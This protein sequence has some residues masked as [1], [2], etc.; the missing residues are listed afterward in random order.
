M[1]IFYNTVQ[2]LILLLGLPLWLAAMIRPKRRATFLYRLGVKG[3]YQAQPSRPGSF[4]RPIWIHALSVGEV[5][6][7]Q[8]LVEALDR[9]L[10]GI[11]LVFSAS[12]RT[13]MQTAHRLFGG[14][15][16]SLFYFPYD[17]FLSVR[18]VAGVINPC[19]VVIVETDIWPNFLDHLKQRRVPVVWVN[20]RLSAGTFRGFRMMGKFSRRLLNDFNGIGAQSPW[21]ADRLRDLGI[22]PEKIHITGNVKFDQPE[23]KSDRYEGDAMKKAL[24]IPTGRRILIMGSTH[25]GEE[26]IGLAV[27]N[28]LRRAFDDL[29]IIVAP[30]DPDRAGAVLAR[31]QAMG[32][33]GGFLSS[34]TTA[35]KGDPCE[36]LVVNTMGLLR[37]LYGLADIAFVGGSLVAQGGHNPLEPAAW[38]KP[39]L[40]GPDMSDFNAV[41]HM[42]EQGGGAVRVAGLPQ[43]RREMEKM[44]ADAPLRVRRGQLALKV[45]QS[46]KGAVDKTLLLV[47]QA[48]GR[49]GGTARRNP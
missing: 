49:N 34:L 15:V 45:F 3:P 31:A 48:L 41:A 22:P 4:Q 13:G 39:I 32:M 10:P 35:A 37:P 42:L 27:Y 14:K 24:G 21:D 9:R 6:S 5:M 44:L 28:D 36:V 2:I 23:D 18:R 29:M 7:A 25:P 20:A 46:N 1:V 38:A 30:R 40:F 11:P 47:A 33:K 43:L 8:P 19:L 17:F 12:T 16:R 26:E